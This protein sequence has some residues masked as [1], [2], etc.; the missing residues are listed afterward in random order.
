MRTKT[1]TDQ[2]LFIDDGGQ[3]LCPAHLGGYAA[4]AL[5]RRPNAR[6]LQTPLGTWLRV[7]P[8]DVRPDEWAAI[9]CESCA[10][11]SASGVV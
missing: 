8:D 7:D 6:V 4:S 1:V 9:S 3:T 5:R 10:A 11:A 2:A